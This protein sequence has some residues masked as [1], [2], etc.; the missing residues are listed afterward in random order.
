MFTPHSEN[1]EKKNDIDYSSREKK[2]MK[3]EYDA[4]RYVLCVKKRGI[5]NRLL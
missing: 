5:A 4:N 2:A 3:H 1:T